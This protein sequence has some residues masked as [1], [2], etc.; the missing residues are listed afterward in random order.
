MPSRVPGPGEG[1]RLGSIFLGHLNIRRF[2]TTRGYPLRR[3][4]D[5]DIKMSTCRPNPCFHTFS[6]TGPCSERMVVQSMVAETKMLRSR[7]PSAKAIPF[8]T[9]QQG[10]TPLTAQEPDRSTGVALQTDIFQSL[11]NKP[12]A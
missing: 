6:S 7:K 11:Q 1:P 8:C 3:R 10:N 5:V 2:D 4:I 12:A 9:K